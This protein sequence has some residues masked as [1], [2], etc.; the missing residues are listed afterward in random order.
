MSFQDAAPYATN[1]QWFWTKNT[2]VYNTIAH[3]R[4]PSD[5]FGTGATTWTPVSTAFGETKDFAFAMFGESFVEIG[6]GTSYGTYPAYYGTWA[7]YWE[8]CHTQQLYLA[9]WNH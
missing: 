2:N 5:A 1:G 3:W 9:S 7:N 4:N 6:N 8:N